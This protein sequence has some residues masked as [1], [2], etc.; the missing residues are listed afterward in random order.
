M[1][2]MQ[3]IDN[4]I[5]ANVATRIERLIT[6]ARA[7]VARAVNLTE[8]ITK[9]EIGH[10]IVSVVQEGEVRAAYGKQAAVLPRHEEPHVVVPAPGYAIA[11]EY[12]V[13]V[14][15]PAYS[16]VGGYPDGVPQGV[17]VQVPYE[18]VVE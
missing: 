6:D 13:P 1:N 11:A 17:V 4:N 12:A 16:D 15:V 7:N 5:I 3:S 2:K 14:V 18:V 10:V 9:Y 8:V